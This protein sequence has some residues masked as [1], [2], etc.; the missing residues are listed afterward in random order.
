MSR[1][2]FPSRAEL[3]IEEWQIGIKLRWNTQNCSHY[4]AS[5][6]SLCAIATHQH[7][8]QN[9]HSVKQTY[10]NTHTYF[11]IVML[12]LTTKIRTKSP[13]EQAS[14]KLRRGPQALPRLLVSWCAGN[15][16]QGRLG[17]A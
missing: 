9:Q 10:R 3:D 1:W 16:T 12:A 4:L 7:S 8:Q 15:K 17:D 5:P 14:P 11:L 13:R 2:F 6:V